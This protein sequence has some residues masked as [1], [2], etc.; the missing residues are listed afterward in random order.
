LEEAGFDVE[1]PL[2]SGHGTHRDDLLTYRWQ[3]WY[4]DVLRAANRLQQRTGADNIVYCGL[5]FGALLGLK[6]AI[7]RPKLI[8]KMVSMGTPLMLFHWMELLLPIMRWTPL[9]LLKFWPKDHA[10]AVADPEGC[11]YYKQVSY[12]AFPIAIVPDIRRLQRIVRK[13]LAKITMPILAMHARQDRTAPPHSIDMLQHGTSG[14]VDVVWLEKSY[15]V[16]T[17]DYERDTVNR[18]MVEFL[19]AP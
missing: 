10:Q 18:K 3:D 13:D 1:M 8:T 4:A 14:T 15:H 5:S 19:Q 17:L 7:D 11:A 2:L 9:R 12:D 16:I 6:L